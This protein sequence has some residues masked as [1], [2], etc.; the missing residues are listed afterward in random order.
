[1]GPPLQVLR[2][3]GHP[4]RRPR[5]VHEHARNHLAS[6]RSSQGARCRD[7]L[8]HR[9]PDCRRAGKVIEGRSALAGGP[10]D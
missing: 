7:H 5:P 9:A 3:P 2:E 4:R 6:G 10:L 8:V 1:M